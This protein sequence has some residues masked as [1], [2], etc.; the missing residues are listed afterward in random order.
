M[1]SRPTT[2][3]NLGRTP[4]PKNFPP[5]EGQAKLGGNNWGPKWAGKGPGTPR[6]TAP[7]LEGR[8]PFRGCKLLC[9]GEDDDGTPG[10]V[11]DRPT[12]CQQPR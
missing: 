11:S 12:S 2:L 8:R 6:Q 9:Q 4:G 7:P 10:E 3:G 1:D 5:G